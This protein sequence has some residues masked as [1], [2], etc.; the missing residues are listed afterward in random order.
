MH[1]ETMTI[2][3]AQ[4]RHDAL[5][6]E[7]SFIVQ[8]PAGSGKTGLLIQR[9]LALLPRAG[10]PEEITAITFTRKAAAEMRE[11]VL[12]A[13]ARAQSDVPPENSHEKKTWMLAR[14]AVQQDDAHGWGIRE[15]PARLRICTIDSLCAVLTRQ[16]PVLS[17]FGVQ[18]QVMADARPLYREAA[19]DTVMDLESAADWSDALESLIRHMD[20]NIGKVERMIAEMLAGRDQWLRHV[21]G[22]A[23][24]RLQRESLENALCRVIE[25]VLEKARREMPDSVA[26]R[27]PSLCRFAAKNLFSTAPGSRICE[28]LEMEAIPACI[29][30]TLGTWNGIADLLLTKDG[31]IRKT[32]DK[33]IGF[34]VGPDR[35]AGEKT[36]KTVYTEKKTE[37]KALLAEIAHCEAFAEALNAVRL[38]PAPYYTEDQWHL[39]EALFEILKLS[40]AHLQLVF[41]KHGGVDFTEISLR[42][43]R[44]LGDAQAPTD[45]ALR[46]DYG[47]HHILVDEFQDTSISQFELLLRLTAGWMPGDGKTFF[48]VGDPMQSIYS[49][50]EAEVG[51]F[52]K[53]WESGMGPHLPLQ[54]LTLAANFRSDRG[55]VEWVNKAFAGAFPERSDPATGAVAYSPCRA[56]H[57]HGYRPAVRVHP[58]IDGGDDIVAQTVVAC[59]HDAH[60]DN[61]DENI[62]VLVRGR[63]HLRM[64]LPALRAEKIPYRAVE[65]DALGDRP[66]ISDLTAIARALSHPADRVAWLALLRGPWCGLGLADLFV[67]AGEDHNAAIYEQ[68]QNPGRLSQL[69]ED[70]RERLERVRPVLNRAMARRGRM[71]LRSLVEKTWTALGGPACATEGDI[72]DA[73][74]YLDFLEQKADGP[75]LID[76]QIFENE[77]MGLFSSPDPDAGEG[78]QVMTIH[79]AK[80][81]QFDRV[82]IP[83]LEKTPM[84][85]SEKLLLWQELPEEDLSS[86]ELLLAPIAESGGGGDPTYNYIK[87]LHKK[88]N[89]H[90]VN[91]LLYVAATRAR[92][93]LDLVGAVKRKSTGGPAL[94]DRRA[95]LYSLWPVVEESFVSAC[96]ETPPEIESFEKATDAGAEPYI[97]RLSRRW[98]APPLPGDVSA[99]GKPHLSPAA[100]ATDSDAPPF[101]WAGMTVRMTGTVVHKWLRVICETGVDNWDE[102]RIAAVSEKIRAELAAGGVEKDALDKAVA[103]V[104]AALNQTLADD[105]GRWLLFGHYGGQCEYP[106]AGLVDNRMV[107]VV[108]DRTFIDPDGI[109][110]IVDY[111]SGTHTGGGLDAFMAQERMRYE[112]QTALYTA[113]MQHKEPGRQIRRALYFP[114]FAGWSPWPA[115]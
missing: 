40:V 68:I 4:A 14:K 10:S 18:P 105:T 59:I 58:V 90:E 17:G 62:A 43:Q 51:L 7:R 12:D 37:F 108:I 101:D 46:L 13:M 61:P 56:V 16:M 36:D 27:L 65:I 104:I 96:E 33:R 106:L 79:K 103:M 26:T 19:T 82:I 109:L 11:R 25:S 50:R 57:S 93:R 24:T 73:S 21:A 66:V 78:L 84:A 111:K 32:A 95:L 55:I 53:A 34:P 54:P 115:A 30:E 15:N 63:P 23:D 38:L 71:P 41:S 9:Y 67:L 85:D 91:R 49:F 29:P 42:A 5:D 97:R 74:V 102:R 6:P 87:N 39:L 76:Y 28:C 22:R 89:A 99:M 69:S 52:L 80:G 20:N 64:I 94:P 83:A 1:Q 88:K 8:A 110:W 86:P 3:D 47:I 75:L 114:M 2:P 44:A 113:L 81:L 70:G 35:S 112:K 45:L 92:R 31:G 60:R 98:Q 77:V 72:G 48:A 100:E 107:Y